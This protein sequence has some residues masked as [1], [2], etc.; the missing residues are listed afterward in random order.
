[1]TPNAE[2]DQL[3][4]QALT[5]AL[6]TA[7]VGD[8][9]DTLGFRNQFLPAALVPLTSGTKLAGR[10]MPVVEADIAPDGTIPA[11]PQLAQKPFGLMLEALDALRPGEIYVATGASMSYA[12]WGGLMSARA[13][14]LQAAGAILDGYV[15]DADEI[16]RLGFPVF[17]RGLYAQDQAPRGK[18][19]DFRTT[20]EIG[21]V[22]IR[23]GELLFGDREGVLVIPRE[24]EEETIRLALDKAS[25]E[26]RVGEAIRAGMSAVEAF[27]TFKVM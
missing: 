11:A 20:V 9:L 21:G 22:T 24:A 5:T 17:S 3:L 23:P 18:V 26:N 4:F 13:Q 27:A 15:R 12:L 14:H 8:V 7:V 2:T 1:M 19:I 10:A 6:F 25:A 16:E